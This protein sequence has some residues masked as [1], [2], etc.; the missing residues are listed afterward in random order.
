MRTG[1][2][3]PAL[4]RFSSAALRQPARTGSAAARGSPR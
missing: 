3:G 4:I 1:A 2:D